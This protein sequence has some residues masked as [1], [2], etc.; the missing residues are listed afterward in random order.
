[1]QHICFLRLQWTSSK[2]ALTELIYALY[3]SGTINHGKIS[4][5]EL[6]ATLEKIMDIELG[7][8]HHTF[9]RLRARAEPVKFIEKLRNDL[10]E[11]MQE[12]NE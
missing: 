5:K 8:Y 3:H 7:D 6:V 1:M 10:F 4:L 12:L 2:V 11:R 9:L